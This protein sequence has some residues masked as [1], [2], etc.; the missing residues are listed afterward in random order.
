MKCNSLL[1]LF[2]LLSMACEVRSQANLSVQGSIQNSSGIALA[3]GKYTVVFRLYESE[4]GGTPVWSE[5]QTELDISGGLYSATLGVV[6][7]LTAAF[8]KPYFLGVTVG[9]SP[10]LYPRARLS[11]SPYALSLVGQDNVFPSSGAIGVGTKSPDP[12]SQ[13]HLKSTGTAE[14]RV[15]KFPKPRNRVQKGKQ[16]RQ[17]HLQWR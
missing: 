7:P 9:N 1:L 4:S 12:G 5:T 16:Y 3:D 14:V 15:R 2:A 17:N 13:L 10:E 11:S 6:T 8:D